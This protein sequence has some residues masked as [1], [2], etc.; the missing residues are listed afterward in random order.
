M[1]Q[2]CSTSPIQVEGLNDVVAVSAGDFYSLA[3]KSDGTVWAWG[4]NSSGQLSG[5][6]TETCN[7]TY[8]QFAVP[9]TTAPTQVA[10]LLGV[11]KISAGLAHSLVLKNDGTVWAW[12]WNDFGTLGVNSSDICG[13]TDQDACSL[14]PLQVSTLDHVIAIEAGGANSVALKDDGT[15]YTWGVNTYGQLGTTSNNLCQWSDDGKLY[16]CTPYPTLVPG[17]TEVTA[18]STSKNGLDLFYGFTLALLNDG[19][20]MGWGPNNYGQIGNNTTANQLTPTPVNNLSG[21]TKIAAGYWHSLAMQGDGSI[22]SW[23]R[24][25]SSQLGNGST[26]APQL[27]AAQIAAPSS[28]T[29]ISASA[30]HSM[31]STPSI[32]YSIS[33]S[34]TDDKSPAHS[35]AGVSIEFNGTVPPVSA[36]SV[37]DGTFTLIGIP[38]NAS[39]QLSASKI[40]YSFTGPI[41]I[42]PVS[43]QLIDQDFTGTLDPPIGNNDSFTADEDGQLTVAAPGILANDVSGVS[44]KAVKASDPSHGTLALTEDGGFVYTPNEDYYGADSFTYKANDGDT[45][46]NVATVNI[47][48]NNTNDAPVAVDDSY[49]ATEDTVLTVS[50]ENGVLTNDTDIDPN[51]VL[52]ANQVTGPNHGMA[53]LNPN[54]SFTYTPEENWSGLDTFTYQANDGS[55]NSNVATVTINVGSVNDA[56][57]AVDDSYNGLE[58]VALIVTAADGVLKNDT[59]IDSESL[60]ATVE[61]EPGHGTISFNSDGGFTYTS[62]AN[63]NGADSF[64]YKATDGS[65]V[66]SAAT[67]TIV[68]GNVND[69]PVATN[70]SYTATEDT[71][72]IVLVGDSV[73]NNDVD[74]DEE[75]LTAIKATDPANGAVTLNP[76]G[77]FTYI[78]DGNF[79]GIDSFT[80]KANDGNSDSNAATVTVTVD[81]V[82]DAP[83]ANNDLYHTSVNNAL[84]I[85]QSSLLSNDTDIDGDSLVVAVTT[86][87]AFGTLSENLDGSFTYT[88]DGDYY[89][90]DSFTYTANDG[91]AESNIATVSIIINRLPVASND[92]YAA[93]EDHDLVVTTDNGVLA[94]DMDPDG[95]LLTAILLDDSANGT[96][97]L[98]SD[99]SFNYLPNQDFNG[100]D[101]FTYTANDGLDG[102]PS[103]TVSITVAAVNDAPVAVNDSYIAR[104]GILL[105]IAAPGVLAN[106]KDV[107]E[108]PL[109]V[110]LL[111]PVS[112]GILTVNPDGSFSYTS[113]VNYQGIDTFTYKVSDGDLESNIA[114]V[115]INVIDANRIPI[116][117]ND[118]YT[119]LVDEVL[120]IAAPGVLINDTDEDDNPLTTTAVTNPAHGTLALN[121]DGSFTYTPNLDFSGTDSFTYKVNDGKVN[122]NAATVTITVNRD[123]NAPVA[124]NDKYSLK[125]D[126][127]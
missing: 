19:T 76:N 99:G 11:T 13:D 85:S 50:V 116:A 112:H 61:T 45:N 87:T 63:W 106:D 35:L 16:D 41:S 123:P 17:L 69:V 98:N 64:T 103:V 40:G 23:G 31:V 29:D 95:S 14:V 100:I 33:G 121:I 82:N 79:N 8:Y 84:D 58:D 15:V 57:V 91:K 72:L 25:D 62:S 26:S 109:N 7:S 56:P 22:W 93:T 126:S 6:S 28:I 44:L 42:D 67:V 2:P 107:E 65:V 12:G 127:G 10:G 51:P 117:E 92:S 38:E 5:I 75:P 105:E 43:A 80:Y 4:Q 83:V 90:S 81:P 124:G 66:S 108:D 27:E 54:G 94:N 89:G 47:T 113:V 52:S 97:T 77:G 48:V 46:S 118:S 1:S 96:V 73:L 71:Q 102:S 55:A 3:L 104:W 86:G 78:P 125:E 60:T 120:N 34:V 101:S 30:F 36:N 18:I 122:S 88:P 20:V 9:C 68:V 37:A 110:T 21:I 114:T 119:I 32:Y 53:I 70:D 24:N 74:I 49:P 115:T 111:D 59:D 39:G